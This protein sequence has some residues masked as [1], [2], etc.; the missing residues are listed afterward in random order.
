MTLREYLQTLVE[1][2]RAVIQQLEQHL[3]QASPSQ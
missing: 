2:D 1:R 3:A